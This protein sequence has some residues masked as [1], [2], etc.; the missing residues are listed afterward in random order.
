MQDNLSDITPSSRS[1]SFSSSQAGENVP[2]IH[3]GHDNQGHEVNHLS[4]AQGEAL[5]P[6]NPGK[7][8]NATTSKITNIFASIKTT[9]GRL[10]EAVKKPATPPLSSEQS[11][12]GTKIKWALKLEKLI[13]AR[14]VKALQNIQKRILENDHLAKVCKHQYGVILKAKVKHIAD[15]FWNSG[16]KEMEKR[17]KDPSIL[18]DPLQKETF[19]SSYRELRITDGE[20]T[21]ATALG[22]YATKLNNDPRNIGVY[23]AGG[24]GS[25]LT[26]DSHKST[27]EKLAKLKDNMLTTAR[28]ILQFSS[29]GEKSKILAFP[30]NIDERHWVSIIVDPNT[31]KIFMVDSQGHVDQNSEMHDDLRELMNT[32]KDQMTPP[33][34]WEVVCGEK[35]HP[36]IL[37]TPVQF[38]D[39]TCGAQHFQQCLEYAKSGDID[40]FKAKKNEQTN[41]ELYVL[42]KQG[43]GILQRYKNLIQLGY[44]E[45]ERQ[46]IKPLSEDN[47]SQASP[48]SEK[49]LSKS[50]I[51]ALEIFIN[52]QKSHIPTT[53]EHEQLLIKSQSELNIAKIELNK[54]DMRLKELEAALIDPKTPIRDHLQAQNELLAGKMNK[55][56]I[57]LNVAKEREALQENI[58]ILLKKYTP[59]N[60]SKLK[61]EASRNLENLKKT[62]KQKEDLLKKQEADNGKLKLILKNAITRLDEPKT[63]AEAEISSISSDQIPALLDQLLHNEKSSPIVLNEAQ[64]I[65]LKTPPGIVGLMEKSPKDQALIMSNLPE[66]VQNF[67]KNKIKLRTEDIASP[68]PKK[69]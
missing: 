63:P 54:D 61:L 10:K 49:A 55:A 30:V 9:F 23:F 47:Q 39:Y 7:A 53:F 69:T 14:G 2:S 56:E 38:D 48:E 20:H 42:D 19:E 35:G 60:S 22:M 24:G 34:N 16:L 4:P 59:K 36:S 44:D 51:A 27:A 67:I 31:Q 21:S 64:L 52:K 18:K 66:D 40:S 3:S 28:E 32:I 5:G 25:V 50:K 15:K 12:I 68:S 46:Y 8:A 26:I 17:V 45:F 29:E 1:G 65:L 43:G 13:P 62:T 33:K 6:N 57:E 58:L 41:G 11:E 37:E